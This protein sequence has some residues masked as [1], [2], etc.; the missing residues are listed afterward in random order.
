MLSLAGSPA[1]CGLERDRAELKLHQNE[2][3]GFGTYRRGRF[4]LFPAVSGYYASTPCVT[5]TAALALRRLDHADD[6]PAIAAA[7]NYLRRTRRR[8]GG[9][10]S[11]WWDGET[12]ATA[13]ALALFCEVGAVDDV[14]VA[15][16]ALPAAG[17][18]AGADGRA[19]NAFLSAL[20]A[21][22]RLDAGAGPGDPTVARVVE[23]LLTQQLD[24]GSWA[25]PPIM[26]VPRP[27]LPWAPGGAPTGV[28]I[29]GHRR[30]FV[31]AT[32]LGLLGRVARPPRPPARLVPERRLHDSAHDAEVEAVVGEFDRA[33][34]E[35]PANLRALLLESP[36]SRLR[37]AGLSHY[38]PFWLDVAFSGGGRRAEARRMA[39]ANRFG[40]VFC[41]LQDAVVDRAPGG[42]PALVLPLDLLFLR[43][44]RGYQ[45]IFEASHPFWPF[46]DRYWREYLEAL[47]WEQRQRTG[48]PTPFDDESFARMAH[49]FSPAKLC[50]AAMALLADRADAVAPLEALVDDLQIAAQI[51]DDLNDWRDD[52]EAGLW[53]WPLTLVAAKSGARL[54]PAEVERRLFN[55]ALALEPLACAGGALDRA[56][57]LAGGLGLTALAS[58]LDRRRGDFA[59]ARAE[60]S[61]GPG[62][63]RLRASLHVLREDRLLFNPSTGIAY[64]VDEQIADCADRLAAIGT[65]PT[66]AEVSVLDELSSAGVLRAEAPPAAPDAPPTLYF[67]AASPSLRCVSCLGEDAEPRPGG[68]PPAATLEVGRRAIELTFGRAQGGRTVR[69]VLL[70]GEDLPPDRAMHLAR[71]ASALAVGGGFELLLHMVCDPRRVTAPLVQEWVAAG[72]FVHLFQ[73][74]GARTAADADALLGLAQRIDREV[75]ERVNAHLVLDDDR[76]D[77]TALATALCDAGFGGVALPPSVRAEPWPRP[78]PAASLRRAAQDLDA[79]A[80]LFACALEAGGFAP[81]ADVLVPL[82]RVIQRERRACHCGAGRSLLAATAAGSLSPCHRL[83][84]APGLAVGD[85]ATGVDAGAL[86]PWRSA[87]VDAQPTCR[88]CW[89][90]YLCGGGCRADHLGRGG[91]FLRPDAGECALIEHRYNVA[92]R[93]ARRLRSHQERVVGRYAPERFYLYAP[94]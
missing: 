13:V 5:A 67:P 71:H 87:S 72:A 90:R 57:A 80:E 84:H 34:A 50:V 14:R 20:E 45:E 4:D 40:Q 64:E 10:A 18:F 86:A 65:S 59:A 54:E 31:T 23:W 74:G 58:W 91:H 9:W 61:A 27:E 51:A 55:D 29:E 89:A 47:A 53:T 32:V 21:S 78:R 33:V 60:V 25:A 88:V 39:L 79:L 56:R 15:G 8:D 85:V 94:D 41:L 82:V 62:G 11:F 49:K 6:R 28:L 68:A 76:A 75:L 12:Y 70:A 2:D 44:V 30:T 73:D 37:G 7:L 24:D 3:G 93:L 92:I 52:L 17:P 81:I 43:C 36:L 19:V 77:L 66:R 26:R 16:D 38:L 22:A 35:M 83:T 48:R 1:R 42:S 63:P 46:F 69:C